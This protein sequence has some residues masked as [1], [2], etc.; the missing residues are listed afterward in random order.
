M[1]LDLTAEQHSLRK[2]LR[3]YYRDLFT[4]ELR[5]ALN[6]EWD[7]MGGSVFRQVV[8]RMGADGWLGIGWPKEY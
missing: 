3:S 5:A 8:A 4:P 7:D 1:H 2:Q 6:A